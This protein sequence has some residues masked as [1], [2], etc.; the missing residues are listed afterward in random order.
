MSTTALF[1]EIVI[2][3]MQASIWIFIL[4]IS[5]WP[6]L[7]TPAWDLVKGGMGFLSAGKIDRAQTA[8]LVGSYDIWKKEQERL[9]P[10]SEA[11]L[12]VDI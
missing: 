9:G 12:E 5:I 4:V 7:R 2:I 6:D 8:W 1:A 10:N 3:G 11:S